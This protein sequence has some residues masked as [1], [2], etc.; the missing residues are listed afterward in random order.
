MLPRSVGGGK[1]KTGQGAREGELTLA[2]REAGLADSSSS[3]STSSTV[4][5]EDGAAAST[6]E[7]G[8]NELAGVLA[9][10]R[11]GRQGVSE[12]G[13]GGE[14]GAGSGTTE[15]ACWW[16]EHGRP[17]GGAAADGTHGAAVLVRPEEGISSP[18][19]MRSV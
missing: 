10:E 3:S 12:V 11:A 4:G 5:R 7:V 18:D 13:K 1:G 6:P 16:S 2:S 8:T 14:W 17:A 9:S 15:R 19:M